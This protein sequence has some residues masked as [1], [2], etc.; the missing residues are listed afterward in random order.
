MDLSM[1]EML[2]VAF[3]GIL[4]GGD[5]DIRTMFM[6]ASLVVP[7]VLIKYSGVTWDCRVAE[8]LWTD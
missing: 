5:S 3:G 1:V 8:R 4:I 7:V 6:I 2:G